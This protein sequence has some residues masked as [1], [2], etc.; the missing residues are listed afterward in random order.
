MDFTRHIY[1]Q[2][3]T[4]LQHADYT[5][6]TFEEFIRNPAQRV[7][8][9]RHD[10]DKLPGNALRMARLEYDLGMRGS[11]YF[12]VIPSVW[13]PEVMRQIVELG[14]EL[15]YHYEDL[16]IA[17]GDHEAAI[18]HFKRQL[19]L[20][21]RIYPVRT[22]CMHGSPLSRHDNRDLWQTYDYRAYG[23][24]GEPYF[25]VDFNKVF[26]ATDTGRTWKNTSA[27]IRDRVETNFSIPINSTRHFIER[28]NRQ[29]LPRQ[30]MITIHPQRWHDPGLPWAAELL[31]QTL[32]NG[33]KIALAKVRRR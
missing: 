3:L 29:Q 27:S 32:K 15:G 8:V 11:Y 7:V 12:R 24:I 10:I 20:F 23:I 13:C 16:T 30:L 5:F 31:G 1:R 4:T 17:R 26:Y 28:I 14:H 22:V 21:R 2:L 9:L 19:K 18:R 6:Q 33:I 25:D